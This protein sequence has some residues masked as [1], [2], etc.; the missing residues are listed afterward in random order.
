MDKLLE[1][2]KDTKICTKCGVLKTKDNF[3]KNNRTKSGIKSTCKECDSLYAKKHYKDF[4]Q[5]RYRQK[6][7]SN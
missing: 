3:H 7:G 2:I 1:L 5:E 6:I 4:G